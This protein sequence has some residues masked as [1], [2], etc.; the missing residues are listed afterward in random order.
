MQGPVEILACT[1]VNQHLDAGRTLDDLF[2]SKSPNSYQLK[3]DILAAHTY[4]I[5]FGCHAGPEAGDGGTWEV[6]FTKEGDVEGGK[7]TSHW[8]S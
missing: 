3:T 1:L 8:V 6:V 5:E 2:G 7:L 4:L